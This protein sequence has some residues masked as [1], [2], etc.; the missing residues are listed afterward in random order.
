[1]ICYGARLCVT[2]PAIQAEARRPWLSVQPT[3]PIPIPHVHHSSTPPQTPDTS[4]SSG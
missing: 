2:T 4:K 3:P 1:M